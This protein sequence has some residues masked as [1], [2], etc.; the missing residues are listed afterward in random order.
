[1]NTI[2]LTSENIVSSLV[3]NPSLPV[4]LSYEVVNRSK[5]EVVVTNDFQQINFPVQKMQS[6]IESISPVACDIL[7]Y[8]FG[9]DNPIRV[10]AVSENYQLVPNNEVFG[11]IRET[12]IGA[13][14]E[15][16]EKFTMYNYSRFEMEMIFPRHYFYMPN[17]DL[18]FL[19]ASSI[20]SYSSVANHS[21]SFGLYRPVCTN[22]LTVPVKDYSLDFSGKHTK[23]LGSSLSGLTDAL[24]KFLNSPAD[25]KSSLDVLSNR[26]VK[27]ELVQPR[28]EMLLKA[29]DV[30]NVENS[31]FNTIE[32]IVN[33]INSEKTA[34]KINDTNDWLI[35]NA[36][37]GYIYN[38]ERNS[39]VSEKRQKMDRALMMTISK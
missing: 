39:F 20:N 4:N 29:I 35:Y 11:A 24:V 23:K 14:I 6:P 25:L 18:V 15:F 34:L 32:S 10:N 17:G 30:V 13:G 19:K 27:P 2:I 36:I 37:N 8:P 5:Q 7:V 21:L 12:V 28:I 1:M 16:V 3:S 26:I 38:N 22:G 9:L 31:K 33:K